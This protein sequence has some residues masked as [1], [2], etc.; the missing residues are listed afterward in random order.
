M[1]PELGSGANPGSRTP[2]PALRLAQGGPELV[3]G[4]ITEAA[5]GA[6][7]PPPTLKL[8]RGLAEALAEADAI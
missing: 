4:P 5:P 7:D 3:E 1:D 2:N 6:A 8:R